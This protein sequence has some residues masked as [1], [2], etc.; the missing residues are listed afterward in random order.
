MDISFSSINSLFLPTCVLLNLLTFVK[1]FNNAVFLSD[2]KSFSC[3]CKVFSR[4]NKS[5]SCS[6]KSF[7]CYCERF[8]CRCK[9]FSCCLFFNNSTF[10]QFTSIHYEFMSDC[11]RFSCYCK[12]F[13]CYCEK[14][15]CNCK[16]FSCRCNKFRPLSRHNLSTCVNRVKRLDL[17][18]ISPTF[19]KPIWSLLFKG[20]NLFLAPNKLAKWLTLLTRRN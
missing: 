1:T 14:F 13:T 8:S 2:C 16:S 20:S 19:C 5:F 17:C 15:S 3:Y 7:S 10:L 18:V 6:C 9:L 4:N 12:S 11:E